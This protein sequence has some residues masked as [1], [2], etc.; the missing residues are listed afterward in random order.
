M[1][2]PI[3]GETL[4]IAGLLDTL[5][6]MPQI[7]M[8]G[9]ETETSGAM[10][11]SVD[12]EIHLEAAGRDIVLHIEAKQKAI[13]PRDVREILWRMRDMSAFT[14]WGMLHARDVPFLAAESISPGAK[15]L[16]RE[17][18]VGYFDTGGSLYLPARGAFYFTDKPVPKSAA[19]AIRALFSGKRSQVAHTLLREPADWINVKSI[20]ER[21]EVSTATASETLSALE[22][23]DW[24][25]TRGRGPSK[26]RRVIEPGALLDAWVKATA[27]SRSASYRRFYVPRLKNEELAGR[28]AEM[29]ERADATYVVTGESAGQ[30]Y[31]PYL[32][33]VSQ[34]KCKVASSRI[35]DLIVSELGARAV[36][37]GANLL[38]LETKSMSEFLFR[39]RIKDVWLASP[40]L[41]YLELRKS[42]GR[43]SEIADHLR[44]ERIGF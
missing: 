15:E 14:K 34:L 3:E 20:A 27:T 25:Q 21:A 17:E 5:Q 1:I 9:L 38:M 36:D 41:V 10:D 12:A 7:R 30:R 26:E 11:T 32:S 29:C 23:F 43:S 8:F 44:Q 2:N 18:S 13:Y 16:L 6:R 35:F 42:A 37:E 39:E 40:I 31:T 22:R 28:I 24:I 19:K 4:L 33:N